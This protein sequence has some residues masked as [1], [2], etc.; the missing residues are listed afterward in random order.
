MASGVAGSQAQ[1]LG[2]ARRMLRSLVLPAGSRPVSVRPVPEQLRQLYSGPGSNT[3]VDAH[4]LVKLDKPMGA[5]ARFLAAWPPQAMTVTTPSG[6]AGVLAPPSDMH[7]ILARTRQQLPR[8]AHV[9]PA[10]DRASWTASR[11]HPA[12]GRQLADQTG[13][14]DA[15]HR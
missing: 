4:R 9:Q 6:P 8:T 5:A 13:I 3:L 7:P 2:L 11:S 15:N 1:A 10:V 14:G 12:P